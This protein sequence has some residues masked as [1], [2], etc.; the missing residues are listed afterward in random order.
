MLQ[1]NS[2]TGDPRQLSP[3]SLAF[4]GDGVFELL[5]RERLLRSGSMPAG[6]LHRLAVEKVNAKGQAAAYERLLEELSQQETDILKR[7]RNANVKPPKS[8]SAEEYHKATAIEALFGYLY[9]CGEQGRLAALF[10]LIYS[11]GDQ[12]GE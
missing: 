7:G 10:E 5:V 11:F 2:F 3:L 1:P 12:G 8:C 9:L 6:K 4:L